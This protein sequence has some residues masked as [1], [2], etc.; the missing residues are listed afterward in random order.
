MP[1]KSTTRVIGSCSEATAGQF[2]ILRLLWVCVA[3]A[4]H[5]ISCEL[6]GAPICAH[7]TR[8]SLCTDI[9]NS[10]VIKRPIFGPP[11]LLRFRLRIR[12]VRLGDGSVFCATTHGK[13]KKNLATHQSA[14]KADRWIFV[15]SQ[16]Q[17]RCQ[18]DRRMRR[19]SQ[20]I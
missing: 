17:W 3:P 15:P 6:C 7:R 1:T 2:L 8:R 12:R 4:K 19:S 20:V 11:G 14:S 9:R 16:W 10:A 13:T 18:V 5:T